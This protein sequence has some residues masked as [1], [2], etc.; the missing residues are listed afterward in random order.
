[1]FHALS[2][3]FLRAYGKST[4]I[5]DVLFVIIMILAFVLIKNASRK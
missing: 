4:P 3:I 1:M 5:E 2:M